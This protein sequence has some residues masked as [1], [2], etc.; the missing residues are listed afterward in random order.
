MGER[1]TRRDAPLV[2]VTDGQHH[3]RQFLREALSEFDFTIYECIEPGELNDALDAQ[4][5]DL[6]VLGMTAGGIAAGD[7]LRVLA[8]KDFE[9]K[10]LPFAQRDSAVLAPLQDLAEQIGIALLPPLLMPFSKER[11]RESIAILLPESASGPL[12][13]MAE[14]VRSDRDGGRTARRQATIRSNASCTATSV[15]L[16][17]ASSVEKSGMSE[18]RASRSFSARGA[19]SATNSLS[20]QSLSTWVKV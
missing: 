8:A 12:V 6:L 10:A 5:P 17:E 13:D 11:L 2:C 14:A 7:V 16:S 18:A 9:C 19:S 1:S 3:V 15:S 4:P 20:R